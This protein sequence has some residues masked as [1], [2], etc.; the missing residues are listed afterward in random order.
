MFIELLR[1]NYQPHYFFSTNECDFAAVKDDK[2]EA[3]QVTYRLEPGNREREFNGIVEAAKHVRSKQGSILT[4]DEEDESVIEGINIKIIP[5][6]KW[7]ILA[8]CV[9]Q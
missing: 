1:R 4:F 7:L 8:E 3:I 9:N 6:W 5:T 2:T